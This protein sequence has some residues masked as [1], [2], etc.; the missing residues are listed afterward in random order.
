MRFGG[1]K[2]VSDNEE[3]IPEHFYADEHVGAVERLNHVLTWVA[4]GGWC[5]A[6]LPW[7]GIL[8]VASQGI[9]RLHVVEVYPGHQVV[10]RGTV[11]STDIKDV[12]VETQ[13]REW[14]YSIR[15]RSDDPVIDKEMRD[16]AQ[17]MT[18][19]DAAKDL[20]AY[21]E[22]EK[23][24]DRADGPKQR[25]RVTLTLKSITPESP[26][27]W[28]IL[29]DEEW[30]PR[31]GRTRS[32]LS[33]DGTFVIEHRLKRPGLL[34]KLKIE[35]KDMAVSPLGVF[36]KSYRWNELAQTATAVP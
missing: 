28:R 14:L 7:F 4:I 36:V 24:A 19:G 35:A 33:F 23:A 12:W 9:D 17:K 1:K 13:L 21:L 26:T 15:R 18:T 3:T 20:K 32:N 11:E 10:Y 27:Q 30:T 5:L 2:K 29:W 31:V 6:I 8:R 16:R 34:G 22:R 25:Q